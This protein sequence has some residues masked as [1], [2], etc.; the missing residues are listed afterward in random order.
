MAYVPVQRDAGRIM[1]ESSMQRAGTIGGAVSG[2]FQALNQQQQAAQAAAQAKAEEDK[3]FNAKLKAL[4]SLV[5]THKDKFNLSDEQVKQFLSRDPNDSAKTHYLKLGE[6]VERSLKAS[7]LEKTQAE[8]QLKRLEAVKAIQGMQAPARTLMSLDELQRR[9]PRE[10][11]DYSG[12]RDVAGQPGVVDITDMKISGRGPAAPVAPVSVGAGGGTLVMPTGETRIIPAIPQAGSGEMI[13]YPGGTAP[14]APAG[15]PAPTSLPRFLPSGSLLKPQGQ[16]VPTEALEAMRPSPAAAPA[17]QP[18][19]PYVVELE[20]G[21]AQ[22]KRLAAEQVEKTKQEREAQSAANILVGI[23]LIKRNLDKTTFGL[24]PVGMYPGARKLV[25]QAAVDVSRGIDTV[26]ANIGF[27]ELEK[28]KAVGGT[29]GQIA[30][31]EL[32]LLQQLRGSLSQDLSKPEFKAAVD[33]LE[34]EAENIIARRKLLEGVAAEKRNT[35]TEDERKQY[36]ALGGTFPKTTTRL[37]VNVGASPGESTIGEPT[38]NTSR[39]TG[40]DRQAYEWLMKNPKDPRADQIRR[41]LGL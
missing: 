13:V 33:R 16:A 11:F 36:E 5:Q 21:E 40:A 30:I 37:K 27:S 38:P 25:S 20:G 1:Y 10:Q 18:T 9:Y 17:P 23:G 8:T 14:Q 39:F 28:L 22:R 35:L 2:L 41:K 19:R 15:L 34:K 26:I 4:E 29:L 6:F 24:E 12:I 32:E 7:E 31:R 3:Q